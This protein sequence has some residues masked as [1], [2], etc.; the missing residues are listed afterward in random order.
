MLKAIVNFLKMKTKVEE[1]PKVEV[2]PEPV[3]QVEE[4]ST[5]KPV[6]AK[7]SR[8]PRSAPVKNK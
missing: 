8:S 3:V 7:K 4:V 6:P 5:K 1:S 2:Q